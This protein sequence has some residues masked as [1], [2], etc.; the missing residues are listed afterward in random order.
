MPEKQPTPETNTSP[1]LSDELEGAIRSDEVQEILSAVPNWMIRWGITL[2]FGLILMLVFISWFIKYPD[3]I[4]G[5]V[6]L[7]TEQPP[8]KLIS[9]TNGYIEQLYVEDNTRLTKGQTIAEITSPTPKETIDRLNRLFTNFKLQDVEAILPEVENIGVLGELQTDFN[10]LHKKLKEY[11]QLRKDSFYKSTLK[12]LHLQIKY[13]NR[14]AWISKSEIDLLQQEINNA[15]EKFDADSLLYHKEV[16]SKNEFFSNQS[17][18][19]GK[20]QQLINTKKNYLQNK[21]TVA[22]YSNQKM[23]LKK[24]NADQMRSLATN[25]KAGTNAIRNY[26][27]NWQQNY[28][29]TSPIE[30]QLSYLSSI[31]TNQYIT[32]QETLF[33]VTP[34]NQAYIGN[35]QIPAKG[36]GK[37]ATG[38]QV[39][40]KLDNYP[41]QEYGQLAGEIKNISQ[42]AG[43]EGYFVQVKLTKGLTSTYRREI[44]YAPDMLGVAEIITEDLRLIDRVF[45]KSREVLDK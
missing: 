39:K 31:T 6:V 14:L 45:N 4:Q 40:I 27:E 19:L 35:V 24:T 38:Q 17:E 21:I 22:N 8:V 32:A 7:T 43:K 25:I 13:N 26:T 42:I 10:N 30:G 36:Y 23:E 12:H 15:K 41:Y 11:H 37:I 29:I 3:V 1:T 33:A 20:Q 2:V 34:N 9:K 5:Q 28:T 44:P 16:I 18:Y